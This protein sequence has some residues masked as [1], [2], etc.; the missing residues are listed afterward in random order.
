MI[1]RANGDVECACKTNMA[2]NSYLLSSFVPAIS[3][4]DAGK[5]GIS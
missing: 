3:K 1:A 2:R 5:G 4:R